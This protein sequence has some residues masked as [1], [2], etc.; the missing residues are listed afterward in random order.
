MPS[1][2]VC[3]D[4]DFAF[5][6]DTV[7]ILLG[8]T[9]DIYEKL[10]AVDDEVVEELLPLEINFLNALPEEFDRKVYMEKASEMY[11]SRA[12]A[13]RYIRQLVQHKKI[14]KIKYNKYEKSKI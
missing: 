1:V 10:P 9:A 6:L 8:H 4:T 12:S 14:T 3:Q 2:L 7:D 11:I 5:A 13:D